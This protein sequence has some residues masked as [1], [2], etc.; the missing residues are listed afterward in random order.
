MDASGCKIQAILRANA[1]NSEYV[2][3]GGG[4]RGGSTV[5]G[6][7]AD[8]YVAAFPVHKGCDSWAAEAD[9]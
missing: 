4:E 2:R 9:V 1:G 5:H 6:A 3:F 7:G 8:G